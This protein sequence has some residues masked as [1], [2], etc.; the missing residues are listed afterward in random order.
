MHDAV[1]YLLRKEANPHIMD[2][3]NEDA[4]DKAKRSGFAIKF[5]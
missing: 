2:F 5:W 3:N 1:E 4:C